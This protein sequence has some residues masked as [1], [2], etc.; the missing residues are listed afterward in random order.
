MTLEA[1]KITLQLNRFCKKIVLRR[2]QKA[3]ARKKIAKYIQQ[4]TEQSKSFGQ[5]IL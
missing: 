1:G 4:N 5:S 2:K 3:Q